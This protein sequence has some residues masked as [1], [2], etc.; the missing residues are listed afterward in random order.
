[1]QA[2]FPR[3]FKEIRKS[4]ITR[5][6]VRELI[7]SLTDRL[8]VKKKSRIEKLYFKLL[9]IVQMEMKFRNVSKF[10]VWKLFRFHVS[11]QNIN[12]QLKIQIF[13]FSYFFSYFIREY[14]R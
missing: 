5:Y 13:N 3:K 7:L 9:S 6:T 1:F 2:K 11:K 10:Q 12:I 8:Q 14:H 4:G